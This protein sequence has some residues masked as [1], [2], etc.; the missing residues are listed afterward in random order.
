LI[1]ETPQKE[2]RRSQPSAASG[3]IRGRSAALISCLMVLLA[4]VAIVLR[5]K[6]RIGIAI[7]VGSSAATAG[8]LRLVAKRAA[9][10]A[11]LLG[12]KRVTRSGKSHERNRGNEKSGFLH[13]DISPTL[14]V[15]RFSAKQFL[16]QNRNIFYN[17]I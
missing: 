6:R 9:F 17:R 14:L 7:R 4:A 8:A 5:P 2:G 11:L 13:H 15:A 3:I 1:D 16:L 10:R 12:G